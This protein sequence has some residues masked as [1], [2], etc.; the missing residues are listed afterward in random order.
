MDKRVVASLVCRGLLLR[1]KRRATMR[2]KRMKE[3]RRRRRQTFLRMRAMER[4]MFVVL[5]S[6]TCNLSPERMIWMKERAVAIGGISL[7][8]RHGIGWKT[9]HVT[10]YLHVPI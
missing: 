9:P 1:R 4:L 10:E 8:L 7:R 3:T 2:L 6:V 5:M